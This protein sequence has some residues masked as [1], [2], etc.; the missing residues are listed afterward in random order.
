VRFWYIN[1]SLLRTRLS[2]S[3]LKLFGELLKLYELLETLVH[4]EAQVFADESNVDVFF[5]SLDHSIKADISFVFWVHR[6]YLKGADIITQAAQWPF[7]LSS[8][9]HEVSKV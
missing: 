6:V 7:G 9:R 3:A 1:P 2:S 8:R 5:V 4:G